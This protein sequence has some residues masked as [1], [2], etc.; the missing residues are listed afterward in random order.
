MGTRRFHDV[1]ASGPTRATSSSSRG[2]LDAQS[3]RRHQ[4]PARA[5]LEHTRFPYDATAAIRSTSSRAARHGG[6]GV[7]ARRPAAPPRRA[8]RGRRDG[9]L[10]A[11]RPAPADERRGA[12]AAA[13]VGDP[14]ETVPLPDPLS[15]AREL[16][17]RRS[18]LRRHGDARRPARRRRPSSSTSRGCTTTRSSPIRWSRP[19]RRRC[20]SSR[21]PA[22]GS[23]TSG[24][25]AAIGP[26][27]S[28]RMVTAATP[29]RARGCRW[30]R[31]IRRRSC[32]RAG[33]ARHGR[34]GRSRRRRRGVR[35]LAPR[36]DLRRRDA[37]RRGARRRSRTAL[38]GQPTSIP[39]T[40][41]PPTIDVQTATDAAGA[42]AAV[43]EQL[44]RTPRALI[45]VALGRSRT[46]ERHSPRALAE[47]AG[48]RAPFVT[49]RAP[50]ATPS[51]SLRVEAPRP[52]T[53]RARTTTARGPRATF[54][55][56]SRDPTCARASCRASPRRRPT[57][58]RR[59]CSASASLR[60]PTSPTALRPRGA[61]AADG[62]AA[63]APRASFEGHVLLRAY[64]TLPLHPSLDRYRLLGR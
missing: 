22:R 23:R 7:Q 38:V 17:L 53:T 29:S 3:G 2:R 24:R 43:G 40:S 59:S 48:S 34:P 20:A 61:D 14:G 5:L 10:G 54:R 55:S 60:R 44:A 16:A 33:I 64:A 21:P 56:S 9:R 36:E 1:R 15:G 39:F 41:R 58:R 47:L 31:T 13:L 45:V 12:V 37:L 27:R 8:P 51:S 50:R 11:G 46:A 62:T 32:C 28:S 6:A 25:A 49:S 57:S 52:S 42:A 4:H 26:S 30:P 63:L 35:R 19:P 18:G